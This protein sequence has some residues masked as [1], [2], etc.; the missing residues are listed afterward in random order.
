MPISLPP[1]SRRRFLAGSLAAG[2]AAL[3][4]DGLRA[5]QQPADPRRWI[6]LADTHIAENRDQVRRGVKPAEGFVQ[7]RR[8]ILALPARAAG[9]LVAGDC[10]YLEGKPGDY[11]VLAEEVKPLRQSGLPLHFALGNH[12]NRGNFSAAFADALPKPAGGPPV[13]NPPVADK[14][15]ALLE[16]P[17][18]NW[19]LLDSLVKTNH[20]PGE[21]GKVQL[22]WLARSL[23]ARADKPAIVLAHHDPDNG[24]G[25]GLLDTKAFFEVLAP[26]KQV[27]AYVFGHTHRWQLSEHYGIHLINLPATAWVFAAAEARGWVDATL[28]ADGIN[29]ELHCLDPKH[30]KHGE[31][32]E[33][34]WRT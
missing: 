24:L 3:L 20:T 9:V 26:R 2:A 16:T 11:R 21:L 32:A 30:P 23:D 14:Y 7:T 33:L 8:E 29:L 25:N 1:I 10:V 18:V 28:T 4:P 17:H 19:F 6:L 13:A 5:A 22:D 31:K 12:D 15:V 34:K 27:K